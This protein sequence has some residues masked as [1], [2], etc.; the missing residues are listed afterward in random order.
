M[1]PIDDHEIEILEIVGVDDELLN[2][3]SAHS[4]DDEAGKSDAAAKS[5]EAAAASE[6]EKRI[7]EIRQIGKRDGAR[8]VLRELLEPLDALENCIREAPDEES[9]KSGIRLAL[10]QLWD[11]FRH[12]ELER[13]EGDK[14]P[15]DP[16]LH[17]AAETVET[18]R[19]PH[20]TV[21]AVLRV[22]YRLGG[23]LVRPALVRVSVQPQGAPVGV[24]S[25]EEA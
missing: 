12:H 13:I 22:G 1:S 17:E 24:G 5:D 10:R 14:L 4:A 3:T 9:M 19:V 11:V 20:N 18:D 21:I 7:F 16:R 25:E 6:R 8:S 15:F 23:E 2:P